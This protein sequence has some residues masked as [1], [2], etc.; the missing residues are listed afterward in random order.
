MKTPRRASTPASHLA[1]SFGARFA[2]R[3]YTVAGI[4]GLL[5]ILPGFFTEA[6][7]AEMFPPPVTH[8]ELYYG[9]YAV[10]LAWQVAFLVIAR[11]PQRYRPLMPVTVLEKAG[12]V[13]AAV[14]LVSVGR[15]P[16][17]TLAPAAGDAIL[18]VLFAWS[19]FRTKEPV[20]V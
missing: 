19:Y 9:F 16:R 17:V 2:R 6:R 14:W 1:A 7:Y 18:G 11:D 4:Y 15:S 20:A 13:V 8:P 3:V 5:T 10:T 12:F